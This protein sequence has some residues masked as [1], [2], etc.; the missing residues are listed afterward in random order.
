MN[1]PPTRVG[2]IHRFGG[3]RW[4]GWN[5]SFHSLMSSGFCARMRVRP[6]DITDFMKR[7]IIILTCSMLLFA[8]CSSMA[9]LAP[10]KVVGAAMAPALN[11]GDR[12]VIERNPQKLERGDI[13]VFYVPFDQD[14]SY[15]KRIIGLPYETVEVREGKFFVN[16]KPLD[17]PYIDPKLDQGKRSAEPVTLAEDR[18]YVVGDNRDNSSDSRIWGPLDR[19]LI[20]GKYLKKY[21]DAGP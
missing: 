15:I 7:L 10:I 20:Y 2:G 6:K 11:D 8:A 17:E 16:G 1:D 19:K 13:V 12:I 4:V 14:F 18:Y 21:Y 3:K 9:S 5:Q